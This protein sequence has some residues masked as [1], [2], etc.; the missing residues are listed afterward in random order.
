M[1][2]QYAIALAKK[3]LCLHFASAY[4]SVRMDL[5]KRA[6]ISIA[7]GLSV[8]A[9]LALWYQWQARSLDQ[10]EIDAY[11]QTIEEQ[12]QI[13]GGRHDMAALEDFLQ[14][15]DGKPFYTVNMYRFQD[16]ADYPPGSEFSGSGEDA[17]ERFSKVMISLM[18]A[19][20]S[21]PVYG[22]NWAH[23][24][25]DWDRVVIVRYR[26]RRDLVDL[27]STDEFADASLHKW[28][29]IKEHNRMLV[30]ATHIPDAKYLFA[31]LALSAGLLIYWVIMRSESNS[32][33]G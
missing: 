11:L 19:R 21:H 9:L 26:S 12:S 30:Q 31:L 7:A 29:S 14:S 23:S 3:P 22:S 25:S 16:V 27:F 5:L 33:S 10:K 2:L 17:Y 8:F 4:W 28:A 1:H 18:T 13:P 24:S 15:D 32:K 6:G 20:G